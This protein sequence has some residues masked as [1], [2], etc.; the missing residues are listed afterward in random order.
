MSEFVSFEDY[1]DKYGTLVYTNV[2]TSML[3]L[4]RQGRDAMVIGKRPEVLKQY[5]VVLYHLNG[6][7]V[8]HR[9]IGGSKA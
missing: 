6:R 5:D 4:I 7:Y 1:L 8:L 3:P 2:G 9:L